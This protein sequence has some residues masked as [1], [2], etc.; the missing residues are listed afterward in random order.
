MNDLDSLVKYANNPKIANNLS[1]G[2]PHPY[3]VEAGKKF[4]AMATSKDPVHVLAIEINGQAAGGIGVHQRDNIHR[5][6]AEL[7]YWLAEDYWGKGVISKAIPMML[8]YAFKNFP[9]ERIF[10]IPYPHN[11]ASEKALIKSGFVKE[12]HI[13]DKLI[14]NNVVM[15]EI[16]YAFRRNML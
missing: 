1:D 8:A 13:K 2:F 11:I 5:L 9:I 15:D 12:A 4:I 3:S 10:A 14:K 7:G 16:T 6:N